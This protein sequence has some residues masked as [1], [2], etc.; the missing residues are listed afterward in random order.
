M[1]CQEPMQAAW[2]LPE[3]QNR[4]QVQSDEVSAEELNMLP[5]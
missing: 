3:A 2:L 5:S 1:D 4:L